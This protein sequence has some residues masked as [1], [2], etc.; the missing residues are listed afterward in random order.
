MTC[1][2]RREADSWP[3][4]LFAASTVSSCPSYSMS[5]LQVSLLHHHHW[6]RHYHIQLPTSS[7][8]PSYNMSGL[9]V[10]PASSSLKSPLS[11]S[12]G[13]QHHPLAS[14]CLSYNMSEFVFCINITIIVINWQTISSSC[15]LMLKLQHV[16]VAVVQPYHH[17]HI[18]LLRH[19][20]CDH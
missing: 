2:R 17:L 16:R 6:S 1:W 18:S 9:Q 4:K 11:L 5:G 13:K 19:H 15:K 8:C 12:I 7:S 3:E 10:G 20:H 14:S